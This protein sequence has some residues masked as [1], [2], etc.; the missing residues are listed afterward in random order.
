MNCET[1]VTYREETQNIAIELEQVHCNFED[2]KKSLSTE[3][4]GKMKLEKVLAESAIAIKGALT[5]SIPA[6]HKYIIL[7]NHIF[8]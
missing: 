3:R 8:Q 6:K 5:V 1:L 4:K 2:V 7:C